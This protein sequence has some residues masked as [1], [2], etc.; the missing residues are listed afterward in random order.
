MS[1]ILKLSEWY[2]SHCI[3]DWHEEFGV[4]IST[5]DN[6]GWELKIDLIKTELENKHFSEVTKTFSDTDWIVASKKGNVFQAYGGAKNLDE[7]IGLFLAWA[8]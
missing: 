4:E 5:L 1:N 6:P 7:M 2:N 3:D 8:G